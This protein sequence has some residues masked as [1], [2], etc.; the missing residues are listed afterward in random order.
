MINRKPGGHV[1]GVRSSVLWSLGFH[2]TQTSLRILNF[3]TAKEAH[4]ISG[5]RLS[6]GMCVSFDCYCILNFL[7]CL[8]LAVLPPIPTII[9][10]ISYHRAPPIN[11]LINICHERALPA[12]SRLCGAGTCPGL[13]RSG[14]KE[15]L[16]CFKAFRCSACITCHFSIIPNHSSKHLL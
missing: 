16:V 4:P 13:A 7:L 9:P 2:R 5:A 8:R 12:R 10:F 11:K 15:K 1:L 3:A 14:W 6:S